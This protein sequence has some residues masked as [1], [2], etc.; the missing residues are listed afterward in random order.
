MQIGLVDLGHVGRA[1]EIDVYLAGSLLEPSGDGLA[2]LD[3]TA[4]GGVLHAV[5]RFNDVRLDA[6]LAF[7]FMDTVT[8]RDP[9]GLLAFR[10]DILGRPA[11]GEGHGSGR[12]GIEVDTAV[13]GAVLLDGLV[14]EEGLGLPVGGVDP[15][16]ELL[17]RH[18]GDGAE[19]GPAGG[20]VG[21]VR[22]A[23][24][25]GGAESVHDLVLVEGA[26]G[27]H[28]VDDEYLP[29][30]RIVRQEDVDMVTVHTLG[31]AD[32][33]IVVVHGDGPLLPAGVTSAAD[34]ALGVLDGNVVTVDGHMALAVVAGL[35]LRIGR[36]GVDLRR[37]LV[38][39][40]DNRVLAGEIR[41][42]AYFFGSG[43][44]FCSCQRC[45][46]YRPSACLTGIPFSSTVFASEISQA[47]SSRSFGCVFAQRIA[48]FEASTNPFFSRYS[49]VNFFRLS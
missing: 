28:L 2:A 17:L 27:L 11:G 37:G 32:V 48:S 41:E 34:G 1:G 29:L 18:L 47:I 42:V 26:V 4:G 39:S 8:E 33:T 10:G 13:L 49:S 35:L 43:S 44:L 22:L 36:V 23:C 7:P 14:L 15:F 30:G 25:L 40:L 45:I 16:P 12:L 9:A 24:L 19:A 46:R 3:R 20:V 31:A 21:K 38:D 6:Y 5:Q